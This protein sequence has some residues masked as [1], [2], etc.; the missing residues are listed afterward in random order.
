MAGSLPQEKKTHFIVDK[1]F[2]SLNLELAFAGRPKGCSV[3]VCGKTGVGKSALINALVGEDVAYVSDPGLLSFEEGAL[4]AGTTEVDTVFACIEGREVR[5]KLTIWD[6][7]GLEDGGNDKLYLKNMHSNCKNVSVILFCID[8]AL[9]RWTSM[10]ERTV[11]QLTETFGIDFWR[12]CLFVLTRANV[13]KP[14]RAVGDHEYFKNLYENILRCLQRD[15]RSNGI[16]IEIVDN[17][18]GVMVGCNEERYLPFVSH[19]VDGD[20]VKQDSIL[21]LWVQCIEMIT[22]KSRKRFAADKSN[23][24]LVMHMLKHQ[25]PNFTNFT[26]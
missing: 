26:N 20:S 25:Q 2:R 9:S 23:H 14:P 12:K 18:P 1:A 21:E 6:S 7:P 17:I 16:A 4:S 15:L 5:L 24:R 10:E 19:K 11:R 22:Q 13:I 8:A 3:L